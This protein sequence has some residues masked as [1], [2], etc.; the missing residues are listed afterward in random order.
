[1][2]MGSVYSFILS[3]LKIP[4]YLMEFVCMTFVD[5]H[6]HPTILILLDIRQEEEEV[7]ELK[8][9]ALLS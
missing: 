1:M 3:Y 2:K 5:I 9:N 8:R 4:K 6:S 7:C